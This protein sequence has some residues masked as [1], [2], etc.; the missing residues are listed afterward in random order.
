MSSTSPTTPAR[1][2]SVVLTRQAW[3]NGEAWGL[4]TMTDERGNV[5][6]QPGVL[7]HEARSLAV[8][9]RVGLVIL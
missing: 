9:H 1:V 6:T 2:T 4:A 3:M 7:A 5:T 8:S